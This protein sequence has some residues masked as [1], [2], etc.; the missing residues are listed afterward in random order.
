GFVPVLQVLEAH[1]VKGRAD[2]LVD[3]LPR[4]ADAAV[5]F[6]AAAAVARAAFGDRD[7]AL[8]RIDDLRGADRIGGPRERIPPLSPS[9]GHHETG[10]DERFQQLADRR[11]AQAGGVRNLAGC[12]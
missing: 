1:A 8:E 6:E 9:S 12:G 11:L 4:H 7:R 2:A 10:A 3:A 5:R